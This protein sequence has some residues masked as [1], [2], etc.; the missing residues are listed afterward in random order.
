[1]L[2]GP[3]QRQVY[4]LSNT[5]TPTTFELEILSTSSD[6]DYT[7]VLEDTSEDDTCTEN[8]YVSMIHSFPPFTLPLEGITIVETIFKNGHI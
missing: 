6:S 3:L 2:R 4:I 1:M 5:V 7:Q 8:I